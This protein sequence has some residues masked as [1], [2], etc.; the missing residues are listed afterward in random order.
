MSWT[1]LKFFSTV[2]QLEERSRTET[3]WKGVVLEVSIFNEGSFYT[4][5][6]NLPTIGGN[7]PQ[8]GPLNCK[9]DVTTTAGAVTG[10]T[11]SSGGINYKVND[12]LI[13]IGGKNN[14]TLTVT[15]VSTGLK[16][17]S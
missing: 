11:L 8:T 4:D 2:L 5:S 7:G 17:A 14:C 3:D 13:V 10:V 6:T 9:V 15:K 1:G 16:S 12:T